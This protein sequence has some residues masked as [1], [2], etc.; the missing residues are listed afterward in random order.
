MDS[1]YVEQLTKVVYDDGHKKSRSQLP[2]IEVSSAKT[3]SPILSLLLYAI[4]VD[5]RLHLQRKMLR[6]KGQVSQHLR[7]I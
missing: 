5:A 4:Y 3:L 2:G 1:S 7:E 6:K